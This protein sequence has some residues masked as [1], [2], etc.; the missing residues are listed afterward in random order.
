MISGAEV[1]KKTKLYG[2]LRGYKGQ[3]ISII[4]H[5]RNDRTDLQTN[6]MVHDQGIEPKKAINRVKEK[7]SCQIEASVFYH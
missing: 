4:E 3:E 5:T 7:S 2:I 6:W 1:K